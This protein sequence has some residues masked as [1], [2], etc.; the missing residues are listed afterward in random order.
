[1]TTHN[2]LPIHSRGY[3]SDEI[4]IESW[5]AKI[6]IS[7]LCPLRISVKH[8]SFDLDISISFDIKRSIKANFSLKYSESMIFRAGLMQNSPKI[9]FILEK[10][11]LVLSVLYCSFLVK[12]Y[13][14]LKG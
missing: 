1:M 3:K 7:V 4:T 5:I 2:S 8:E 6:N 12:D 13:S 10:S 11:G 14:I 9:F